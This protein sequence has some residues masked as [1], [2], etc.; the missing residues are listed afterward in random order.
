LLPRSSI[1]HDLAPILIASEFLFKVELLGSS[2]VAFKKATLVARSRD[3]GAGQQYMIEHIKAAKPI[4]F[5]Y[6]E[7]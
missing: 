2:R 4:Q 5:T 6:F 1:K 7:K 3:A